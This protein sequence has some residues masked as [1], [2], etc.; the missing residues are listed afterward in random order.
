MGE[1]PSGVLS[2]VKG[3]SYAHHSCSCGHHRDYRPWRLF[4]SR[5]AGLCHRAAAGTAPLQV[6]LPAWFGRQDS[7][8]R[9]GPRPRP[10]W[11]GRRVLRKKPGRPP[12]FFL[13]AHKPLRRNR[14]LSGAFVSQTP[15]V[16][17]ELDGAGQAR[18]RRASGAQGW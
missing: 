12:G 5:P 10:H 6:S 13:N 16:P 8:T 4:P 14:D 9:Q 17:V 15:S 1:V 3:I 11:I 18:K 7:N 2:S